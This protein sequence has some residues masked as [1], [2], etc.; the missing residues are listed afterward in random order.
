M[1]WL[2]RWVWLAPLLLTTADAVIRWRRVGAQARTSLVYWQLLLGRWVLFSLPFLV[3]GAGL[4]SGIP[5]GSYMQGASIWQVEALFLTLLALVGGLSVWITH[6]GGARLLVA[7]P[8]VVMSPSAIVITLQANASLA[9]LSAAS[10]GRVSQVWL[11][12]A[13]L[14]LAALNLFTLIYERA[15]RQAGPPPTTPATSTLASPLEMQRA[16]RQGQT[17][18]LL[19]LAAVLVIVVVTTPLIDPHPDARQPPYATG[20]AALAQGDLGAARAA[21][22]QAGTYADA[23][24]LIRESYVLEAERAVAEERW[25]EAATALAALS[26]LR[27]DGDPKAEKLLR[28]YP[29]LRPAVERA[30]PAVEWRGPLQQVAAH[31][32]SDIVNGLAFSPDGRRLFIATGAGSSGA[33]ELWNFATLQR[34]RLRTLRHNVGLGPYNL[35]ASLVDVRPDG[36]EFLSAHTRARDQAPMLAL[37]TM[38]ESK[39]RLTIPGLFARYS[40]DGRQLAGADPEGRLTIWQE[41]TGAVIATDGLARGRMSNVL[42]GEGGRTLVTVDDRGQPKLWTLPDLQAPQTLAATGHE[43]T[44]SRDGRLLAVG[45]DQALSVVDLRTNKR[46]METTTLGTVTHLAFSP[47]SRLIAVALSYEDYPRNLGVVEVRDARDGQ[48]VAQIVPLPEPIRG[49]TFT[50]DGRTL[51]V[52][53]ELRAVTFWRPELP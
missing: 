1:G 23:P 18:G 51:A 6:A 47:D 26:Y 29:E 43:I 40:P 46:V 20:V 49:I 22:R 25:D 7:H 35:S 16:W 10:W 30:A 27:L 2:E 11:P 34:E 50:P 45:N 13:G 31:D 14:A 36:V 3:M 9:I 32:A 41:D 48:R 53:S 4:L 21:L 44:A 24:D 39:P 19:L 33:V 12:P 52:L 15:Q 38:D 5:L 8:G 17:F 28:T 37:W 42:W